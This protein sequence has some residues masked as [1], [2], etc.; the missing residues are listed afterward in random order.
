MLLL[1]DGSH[2]P[3]TRKLGLLREAPDL[4]AARQYLHCPGVD[5]LG[6]L[7][8]H[9]QRE[10][11]P[12]YTWLFPQGE[13]GFNLG[14]GTY[15]ARVNRKELDLAAVLEAFKRHDP[16]LAGR[17]AGAEAIGPIRAHPLRTHVGGTRSHAFR[18]LVL[19]DAAGLV[20]PFTGEGITSGMISGALAARFA[21]DAFASGDFSA[22]ALAP[23]TQALKQR[24]AGDHNAAY[25]LRSTLRDPRLLDHFFRV[26]AADADLARTFALAYLDEVSPQLLLH[27]RNLVKLLRK[28]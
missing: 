28:R 21:T 18:I 26:M 17:L 2:A 27:P 10:I 9:F 22:A 7:E 15:T 23:Y 20:S 25:V 16:I 19:G 12:G 6:P 8:F 13:Y 1:A 3:I 24:F 5:P 4:M 11:L 14:C